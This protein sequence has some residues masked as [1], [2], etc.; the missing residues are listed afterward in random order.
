MQIKTQDSEIK[1]IVEQS[2]LQEAVGVTALPDIKAKIEAKIQDKVDV[3][4]DE[5]GAA[6]VRRVLR[7]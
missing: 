5:S 1:R 6:V 4:I 3:R 7:G 2:G